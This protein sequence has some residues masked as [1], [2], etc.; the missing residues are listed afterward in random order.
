MRSWTRATALRCFR[1]SADPFTSLECFRFTLARASSSWR[2]KRGL[3]TAV[4]SERVANVLSPTSNPTCARHS[5]SRWGS[6]STA[7]EADHLPVEERQ[8]V[9]VLILPRTG[10]CKTILRYPIP[11]AYNLPCLSILKPDCG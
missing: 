7:K 6:H 4:P 3:S 2:K 11:E 9:S 10:R 1:L 8:M 5:G